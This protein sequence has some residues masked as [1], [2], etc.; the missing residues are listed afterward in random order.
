MLDE[1]F[2]LQI[3][4]GLGWEAMDPST[5]AAD[6]CGEFAHQRSTPGCEDYRERHKL[7]GTGRRL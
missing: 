7:R 3:R 5:G 1:P 2:T 4:Q 6:P